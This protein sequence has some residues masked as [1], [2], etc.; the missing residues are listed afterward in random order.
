MVDQA[1]MMSP[2]ISFGVSS[3]RM[4][5]LFAFDTLVNTC[6]GLTLAGLQVPTKLLYLSP[7]SRDRG[8]KI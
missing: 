5:F 6:G 3:G 8:I 4:G 1:T 2:L 7:F